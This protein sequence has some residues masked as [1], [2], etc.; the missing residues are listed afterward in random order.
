[1][2]SVATDPLL[3]LLELPGVAAAADS[4]RAAVDG[5]RRHRVLRR[6]SAEVSA[7]AA[8]HGARASAALDGAD[9]PLTEVRT[10][11]ITDPA[12]QGALRA[13]GALGGLTSTW[14]VAPMQVLARLHVLAAAGRAAELGRPVATDS[15][16][17][18]ALA[19]II[20]APSGDVPAVVRAAVVHGELLA[21]APF[22]IGNGV[23]AR[24]AARLTM[25]TCGLDPK[26]LSVPE[27][28]HLES[29]ADYPA[30]LA[31]YVT[32][33][34]GGVARWLLHCCSAAERGAQ[35]G[36]A[37]CEAVLRG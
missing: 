11:A 31:A 17:L 9:Y 24:A 16:R 15:A 2:P 6:R 25:V 18:T 33:S 19:G 28:G 20:V 37:I 3:P 35:E 8:L 36:L 22:A 12:L 23:V 4:A 27:V 30:A 7:E 29:G 14:R 5:L 10:G 1:M 21:L 26:A 13:S 32:G 34:P